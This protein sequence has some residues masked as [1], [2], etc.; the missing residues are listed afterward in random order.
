MIFY[1]KKGKVCDFGIRLVMI[2]LDASLALKW[3]FGGGGFRRNRQSQ[4]AQL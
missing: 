3:T 2:V 1:S 4:V